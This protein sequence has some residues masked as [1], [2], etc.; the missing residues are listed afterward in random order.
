MATDP[1]EQPKEQPAVKPASD[2][3]D[4]VRGLELIRLRNYFYRDGYRNTMTALLGSIVVNILLIAIVAL[5]Y[6][7]RPAPVYFATQ[8]D[9]KLIEIQ[10]LYEPL[11]DEE[12]LLTWASR[13]GLAAFSYNFLDYQD[14]L[15]QMRQYF[16]PA[17]FDNYLTALQQ[18]GN[19]ETVLSKR[20]VVKAVVTEVPVIVQHG[21]IKGRYAW[22]IEIPMLISYVSASETIEQPI[23]LTMLISRVSTQDKPQGI[24]IAQFVVEDRK[25][26]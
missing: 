5:Q 14:D 3:F 8:T 26:L 4:T 24:A 25:G 7:I 9:G 11:V 18:S 22:K 6:Y 10:P 15:Q 1:K 20:L 2:G 23:L 17:G 21:L 19:L 16:T 12:M 13:A